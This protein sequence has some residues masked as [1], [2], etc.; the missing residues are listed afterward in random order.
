MTRA[1]LLALL[2]HW[3][4]HPG[5]LLTLL[6]GLALATAL[7]TGVQAINAEARASYDRAAGALGQNDLAQLVP[8]SGTSLPLSTYIALRRAGWDVA[9]MIEGRFR[10]ADNWVT[11]IGLDPI[12]APSLPAPDIAPS[13]APDPDPDPGRALLNFI[14]PPGELRGHPETIA[15]ITTADDTNLIARLVPSQD[16]PPGTLVAD[17]GIVASLLGMKDHLTRLLILTQPTDAVPALSTIAPDLQRVAP[18][19]ANDIRGLTDSFHLNLTAFGFLA[20][21]VGLFIVHGTI[22]LAFEQRRASIRTL[23]ALG[24]PLTR[25]IAVMLGE[26]VL[27]AL[28]AGGL[29]VCLGYVIATALLPDVAATLRG[30]YGAPVS[31]SIALRAEWWLAGIA[32]AMA[33]TLLAATQS[34]WSLARLPILAAS[35]PRAWAMGNAVQMRWLGILGLACLIGAA[36]AAN[37]GSGLSA[38][39]GTLGG[40]LLGAALILPGLLSFG[41]AAGARTARGPVT[42]WVWADARQQVPGLS[43]ALMALLLALSANIGVSTMVSSFRTTFEGWLD[44]RLAAELYI[45]FDT[46]EAAA[47]AQPWL[48]NHTDAVLPIPRTEAELNTATGQVYGMGDHATYRTAWPLLSRAT[49]S[50]DMLAQGD[51]VLIN[52]QWANRDNLSVGDLARIDGRP[53]EVIGIYSDYGNPRPQAIFGLAKFRAHYPDVPEVQFALR[54]DPARAAA[55]AGEIEAQFN[56]RPD[57]VLDQAS[58]KAASRAVFERTFVA[59]DALNL[60]TLAVAGFAIFASLLTLQSLRLPQVAPLW[61]LGLTRAR[62]AGLDLLRTGLLALATAVLALPTGLALAWVLLAVVNVEAFGWRLPMQAF[63]GD[64]ARLITAALVAALLAAAL[65]AWRL[66]RQRP[67]DLLKVFSNAR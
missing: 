52:E 36:L 14:T 38:G 22:G 39:F 18:S 24:L 29:G 60:L 8:K 61:A 17:I 58:I 42:Q 65:P 44:Q 50:W 57:Q 30:L 27:L 20:F 25:L 46:P 5:Q 41:L 19:D 67:A 40:L 3:R 4:R 34:L 49:D 43:L 56:L 62:I 64:W 32:M 48:R 66:S 10:I 26:A 23:R 53:A 13:A 55:L 37:F 28:V 33:G 47:Q 35:R 7:W 31:G 63:P 11:L 16:I 9:P 59:T 15:E 6:L 21:A 2:S 45:R 1:A 54:I 12:S 51:G